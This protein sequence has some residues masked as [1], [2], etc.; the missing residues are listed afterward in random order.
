MTSPGG[1]SSAAPPSTSTGLLARAKARESEA[2]RRLAGLYGPVVYGWSRR[3]GLQSADAADVVQDV[4]A[5]VWKSIEGFRRDRPG[6]S[7][8]G[9]LWT[10]TRNKVRDRARD[11]GPAAS[12][13]TDARLVLERLAAAPDDEPP[14]P[15]S[16]LIARGALELVRAEFEPRTW[17]AFWRTT[18]VG[19]PAA[20]VG[21]ELGMSVAAV[22]KCKS[23]VLHR[24]RQELAGLDF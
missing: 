15:P 8:R 20:E 1:Y 23:R 7:F 11:A 19:T 17:Q 6:D 4:F 10:I 9:W 2:W 24:L 16:A 21:E 18:V 12:G 3:C 5:A 14:A 22:Y 13:G